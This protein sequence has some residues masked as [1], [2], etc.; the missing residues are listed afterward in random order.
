MFCHYFSFLIDEIWLDRQD[1]I[2]LGVILF[3]VLAKHGLVCRIWTFQ[4]IQDYPLGLAGRAFVLGWYRGAWVLHWVH[5]SFGFGEW[6]GEPI[7]LTP[8]VVPSPC[9]QIAWA[10]AVILLVSTA[11]STCPPGVGL[12]KACSPYNDDS[13][14]FALVFHIPFSSLR[15]LSPT[16]SP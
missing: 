14:G 16:S 12:V 9:V 6:N 10:R 2:L 8:S 7:F 4:F 3:S 5:R 1:N 13:L 15:F 11:T